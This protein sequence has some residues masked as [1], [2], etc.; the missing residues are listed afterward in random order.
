[1]LTNEECMINNIRYCEPIGK[2]HHIN[3]GMGLQ[4]LSGS[5]Y[6]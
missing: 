4:L 5:V 6:D 2:S 1:M 3:S